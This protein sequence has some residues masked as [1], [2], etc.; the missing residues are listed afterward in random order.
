MRSTTAQTSDGNIYVIGGVVS[1]EQGRQTSSAMR[2]CLKID[3]NLEVSR[4]PQM[5]M[6]RFDTPLA[7]VFER[8][9]MVFGG[10]TSKVHG[11]KRCEAYDIRN[12][13]WHNLAPIP[14]FC[15]NTAAVV[16]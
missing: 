13:Q 6:A 10:K 11:T 8:Y 16:I 12:E 7:T 1:D 4:Q 14:F 3:C 2:D 5:Q 9:I 15:V